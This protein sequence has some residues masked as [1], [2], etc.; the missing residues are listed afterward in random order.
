M[1]VDWRSVRVGPSKK[2]DLGAGGNTD[3]YG[4]L[5]WAARQ[6]GKIRGRKAVL[7]FTDG[8]DY[9]IYD[10]KPDAVAFRKALEKVRKTKDAV[11]LRRSGCRSGTGRRSPQA[12]R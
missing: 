4:A 5:E 7:F 11:S 10:P 2:I 8:A 6:L 9:R 12:T 3:F 1:L